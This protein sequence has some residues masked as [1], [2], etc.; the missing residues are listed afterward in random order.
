MWKRSVQVCRFIFLQ[1]FFNRFFFIWQ[2]SSVTNRCEWIC[3]EYVQIDF[4]FYSCRPVPLEARSDWQQTR[5]ILIS[6]LI[7]FSDSPCHLKACLL[8]WL[9]CFLILLHRTQK[10]KRVYYRRLLFILC[11]YNVFVFFLLAHSAF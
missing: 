4:L 7:L 10:I 3:Y 1:V 11:A 9:L 2:F 5:L 6:W 8:F